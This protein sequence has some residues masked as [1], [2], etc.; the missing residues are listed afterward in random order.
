METQERK[1][2]FKPLE[3]SKSTRLIMRKNKDRFKKKCK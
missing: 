2:A 1:A 3:E